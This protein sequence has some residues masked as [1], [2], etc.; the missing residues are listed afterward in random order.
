MNTVLKFKTLTLCFT[1]MTSVVNA[2]FQL[3]DIAIPSSNA[4]SLGLYAKTPVSLSNGT[5]DI[6]IPIHIIKQGDIKTSV[7]LKYDSEGVL[8]D[9]RPSW[10]GLNWSLDA[11]GVITR[12]VFDLPDDY[13]NPNKVITTAFELPEKNTIFGLDNNLL[14]GAEAGYYLNNFKFSSQNLQ[15]HLENMDYGKDTEPDEFIYNIGDFVGKFYWDGSRWKVEGENIS[16]IELTG[17]LPVPDNISGQDINHVWAMN[18]NYHSKTFGGFILTKSDGTKYFFGNNQNAIEYSIPFNEQYGSEWSATSWYLTKI[19]SPTGNEILF[20]YEPDDY[21]ANMYVSFQY[22]MP[23]HSSFCYPYPPD[24]PVW[25]IEVINNDEYTNSLISPRYASY[26]GSL[27]R[28]VYLKKISTELEDVIFYRENST[29]LSYRSEIFV[30]NRTIAKRLYELQSP[31]YLLYNELK[32]QSGNPWWIFIVNL[33]IWNQTSIDETI[34]M[35]RYW[36]P[37]NPNDDISWPF[38]S[39]AA[40]STDINTMLSSL[41]WKK[42]SKIEIFEKPNNYKWKYNFE[43]NDNDNERLFLEA[44][45]KFDKNGLFE[46]SY[47][48]TYYEGT[49]PD[50]CVERTDHWG[51]LNDNFQ[52]FL[53]RDRDLNFHNSLTIT[54]FLNNYYFLRR[55]AQSLATA[56]TG[57]LESITYPTGGSTIFEYQNHDYSKKILCNTLEAED[58]N[59]KRKAGGL[60]IYKIINK[61]SDGIESNVK[62]YYYVNNF[63][64]L[65]DLETLNSS[66]ILSYDA[67]YLTHVGYTDENVMVALSNHKTIASAQNAHPLSINSMGKHI[68]Y[69]E[70][71]EYNSDNSYTINYFTNFID[72]DGTEHYDQYSTEGFYNSLSY[73]KPLTSKSIERNKLKEILDFNSEGQLVKSIKN[74][75]K[76][77]SK[78]SIP[79]LRFSSSPSICRD[80]LIFHYYVIPYYMPISDYNLFRKEITEY[81]IVNTTSISKLHEFFYNTKNIPSGTRQYTSIFGIDDNNITDANYIDNISFYPSDF[82][83]NK[84]TNSCDICMELAHQYKIDRDKACFG[85]AECLTQSNNTYIQDTTNCGITLRN[86]LEASWLNRNDGVFIKKMID[87]N[88]E[89]IPLQTVNLLHHDKKDYL[90]KGIISRYKISNGFVLL[91][92]QYEFNSMTP[93]ENPLISY[94]DANQNIYIDNNY[95]KKYSFNKYNSKNNLEEF[96]IN[97]RQYTSMLWGHNESFLIA[98]S[99]NASLAETGHTSFE[100]NELNGWI[101]YED[102]DFVTDPENVFTGKGA[103]SVTGNGP[104]Q[105]FTVGQNAEKHSGYKASVWAKGEGAYLHIEVNGE[106]SSHVK[107]RNEIND[108]LW[109]KL[110]VELPRHKIQPYFSQGENLKIKVYVGTEQGTV[111]FD[112]LRFHPSDAQMTTYT[113]EPLIGVTSISNESNKP[114]F[115]IYDS[116]GRLEYIKDFEGN[117]IKKNDYHYRTNGQ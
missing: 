103:M 71:V 54:N 83:R 89:S 46:D 69:S 51:Y 73:Y 78:D 16:N 44:F 45:K 31:I 95:I 47:S 8:V 65:H 29:D 113:H 115:Y 88:I 91:D 117:I 63:Q 64:G 62:T 11:G 35:T 37:K 85:Y 67:N 22:D 9:S 80:E 66:G 36:Q 58:I 111:Y 112:D 90:L 70:V 43:Y 26:D 72:S 7:S 100:N 104:F 10:V 105:I 41:K 106:W 61:D 68:S 20:T 107:V 17:F 40:G 1:L 24:N 49:L 14:F 52:R 101:K 50:Y 15:T 38:L 84:C 99:T 74:R 21:T 94:L 55:P 81:D 34:D 59:G 109:H 60:R 42:L 33:G 56:Q 57:A 92:D 75:Y 96:E 98:R 82:V 30:K 13:D 116:F 39:K 3:P 28:P 53:T 97:S 5:V 6:M 86:C 76:Y 27:I 25:D 77:Y 12:R 18:G 19:L 114:E 23:T 48:F 102:N 93:I 79:S 32:Q 110:E 108:G 2:Q 4:L 87:L